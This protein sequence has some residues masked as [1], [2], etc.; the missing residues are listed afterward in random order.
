V[1][2][3]PSYVSKVKFKANIVKQLQLLVEKFPVDADPVSDFWVRAYAPLVR[4]LR[5]GDNLT[6]FTYLILSSADDKSAAQ[7]VK[8]NKSRMEQLSKDVSGPLLALRDQQPLGGRQVPAWY[9]G[10]QIEAIGPGQ[11]DAKGD[12][13]P[14]G[15]WVLI[16]KDGSISERGAFDANHKRTGQWQLLR[17]DGSVEGDVVY[18]NGELEGVA[19]H[20][21]PGGKL[22]SEATYKN[23]KAEGLLKIYAEDGHLRESRQLAKG[24][25]EGDAI[26][27]YTDG[28]PSFKVL[29]HADEKDGV[30][31]RYYPDGTLRLH[32]QYVQGKT[33]GEQVEYYPDKTVERRMHFM[34]DEPQGPYATYFANGKEREVGQFT[35]GKRTGTWKEYFSNGKLSVEKNYD[36][37][38]ELHGAYHDYDWQGRHYADTSTAVWC[39]PSV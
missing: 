19:R 23:G 3:T 8:S 4:V 14:N 26:D 33:Q 25:Y 11:R 1:A 16:A 30:L 22:K 37:A 35:R 2:L 17:P 13:Q 12:L 7:W 34:Q 6:A 39:A 9:D 10:G 18:N 27:Y 15:N 36:A 38:G 28:K 21:H 29:M 20:Y 32:A 5:Q 31:E 24:N